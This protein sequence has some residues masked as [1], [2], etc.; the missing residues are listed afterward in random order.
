MMSQ[1]KKEVVAL[2]PETFQRQTERQQMNARDP[3]IFFKTFH[4][5]FL[6]NPKGLQVSILPKWRKKTRRASEK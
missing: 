5:S 6:C 1:K 2:K 3:D 4:L